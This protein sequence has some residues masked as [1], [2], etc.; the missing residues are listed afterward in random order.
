M[1]TDASASGNLPQN[2]T[3]H[4]WP[5]TNDF[6]L[7]NAGASVHRFLTGENPR[8]NAGASARVS[9]G[10]IRSS[11]SATG[12]LRGRRS[13]GS[14]VRLRL[15]GVGRDPAPAFRLPGTGRTAARST[16]QRL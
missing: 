14:R 10:P 13:H 4:S 15:H 12:P 5:I 7:V 1:T 2:Y 3:G 16:G 9:A 8:R 6:G 11:R